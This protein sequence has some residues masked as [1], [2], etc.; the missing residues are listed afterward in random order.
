MI[1]LKRYYA[2][3]LGNWVDITTTGTVAD[4]QDPS[5]YFKE[6][7]AFEDGKTIAECFSHGYINVQY[8]GKNYRIDPSC[9]Q[10]VTE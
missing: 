8:E 9:I 3:L 1:V 10:I 7:L 6:H 4:H 2:N 5:T